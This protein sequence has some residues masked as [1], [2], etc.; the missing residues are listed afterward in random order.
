VLNLSIEVRDYEK[1]LSGVE[2]G[3][4]NC[5]ICEFAKTK[6]LGAYLLRKI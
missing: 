2:G 5:K 4:L 6:S 1:Q 3:V